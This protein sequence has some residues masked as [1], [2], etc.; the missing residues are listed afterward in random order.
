M[1]YIPSLE[2]SAYGDSPEDANEMMKE[3]LKDFIDSFMSISLKARHQELIRLNWKKDQLRKK[4]Y[5][6]AHVDATGALQGLD[7][8]G[9]V[10]IESV[11]HQVLAA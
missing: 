10:P 1:L 2:L 9:E 11:T 4:D 5:S 3:V 7:L 8:E 6:H